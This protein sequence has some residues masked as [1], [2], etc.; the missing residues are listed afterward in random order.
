MSVLWRKAD[1]QADGAAF[2]RADDWR[3]S[4]HPVALVLPYRTKARGE[5]QHV[6]LDRPLYAARYIIVYRPYL[7]VIKKLRH[8]RHLHR[9]QFAV[10]RLGLYEK[11][12]ISNI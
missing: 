12:S 9:Q 10:S 3:V 6:G 4:V 5:C 2:I 1:V 11:N 7:S 8:R